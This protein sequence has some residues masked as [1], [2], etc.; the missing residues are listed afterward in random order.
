MPLEFVLETL[1]KPGTPR[2][3]GFSPF[4][5]RALLAEDPASLSVSGQYDVVQRPVEKPYNSLA[6]SHTFDDN[7]GLA[8]AS[9][10]GSRFAKFFD[11]KSK[12]N[13]PPGLKPQTPTGFLSSSPNPPQRQDQTIYGDGSSNPPTRT[14]EDIFEML[15]NSSQVRNLIYAYCNLAL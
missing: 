9:N 1:A 3:Q 7:N 15:N 4:D 14:M 2:T 6:H 8:Y 11:S 12:E 13:A 5:E 10:K